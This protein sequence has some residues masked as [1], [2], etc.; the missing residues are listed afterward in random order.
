MQALIS[1]NS[2]SISRNF[3]PKKLSIDSWNTLAPFYEALKTRPIN[4]KNDL[5]KWLKDRSELEAFV[6]EDVGWRYIKMNID[7]T[8][9]QLEKSFNFFVNEIEPK[10]APYENSFNQKLIQSSFLDELDT[11]TYFVYL[12]AIKKEMEIYRDE[13]IPLKTQLT[14]EA[15]QYGAIS[16][17]MTIE[18]DGKTNTLQQASIYLKST[19]RKLREEVY[20]KIAQRRLQDAQKLDD[21]FTSLIKKRQQLALN[22]GYENYRDYMFAEMG[23]FDYTKQDCFDFHNS[24]AKE[25]VP[26]INQFD[27]NRKTKLKVTSLKPWD[28][29]V[30]VDGKSPL[31]PTQSGAE[32]MDKT[33]ACFHNIH[34]YFGQ[35][36]E[37]M[38][39]MKHVD[40]ESKV[41]KAPGGF[42]YPLNESGVP[43]IYMNSVGS[44]RDMITMLHEGGHA[45]HSFLSHP[46]ALTAFKDVPSEVAELASMSME[47]IS[48]DFWDVFY[49]NEEELKRAKREQ[50]EGVLNTLPWV[51]TIDKFQHLLYE[52]PT[53]TLMQRKEIWKNIMDEFSSSVVDWSDC[54]DEKTY[55]WQKQ[56]HL[57]EVPFYYIE[58]GMAQLGAIAV[59]RNYKNNPTKAIEQYMEA[60]K[61]GYTKPIAEIY[62][63][64]G[65]KFD[66]SQEYIHELVTFVK[67]EL[68]KVEK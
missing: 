44:Q 7:T 23:R 32:L 31:Q 35:C 68:D 50:L 20:K 41:G 42:N 10:I 47:L 14:E 62:A 60:L 3:L 12:R 49:T 27:E 58:Y 29:M 33:I 36:M 11:E 22:T 5:E 16:A 25:I 6:G 54:E 63:T 59:W 30:D 19:D 38:K 45:V 9:E 53:H 55:Y 4:S 43:F 65:I 64:A 2:T 17:K 52:N 26:V 48:M 51:A 1:S 28:K 24:I 46:L 13:N 67:S 40:L 39:E 18:I 34:P 15:Q 21:L 61:L 56:L 8:D 57:F 37:T 66:F